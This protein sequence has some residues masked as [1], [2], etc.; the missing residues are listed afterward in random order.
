MIRSSSV[1]ANWCR[2]SVFHCTV[3][4]GIHYRKGC[5]ILLYFRPNVNSGLRKNSQIDRPECLIRFTVYDLIASHLDGR[6]RCV[7][8]RSRHVYLPLPAIRI[9][10]KAAFYCIFKFYYILDLYYPKRSSLWEVTVVSEEKIH[11][12]FMAGNLVFSKTASTTSGCQH[13][14]GQSRTWAFF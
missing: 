4:S 6:Q 13:S 8:L 3:K 11:L 10:E 5:Q 2:C 9:N 1:F 14:K 7:R 12:S